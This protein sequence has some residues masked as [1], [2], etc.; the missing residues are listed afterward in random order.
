MDAV[1]S[2][3]SGSAM[4]IKEIH[5]DGFGI[6]NGFSLTGLNHGVNMI[7][8]SNEAGKSSL[9]KFIRYTLFGYP[10]AVNDRMPPLEGGAH[11][12]RIKV[13]LSSGLEAVFERSGK[14]TI[15]LHYNGQESNDQN[16]WSQL[17]G[18]ASARL[19]NN[20]YAFSLDELISL[21]P[22]SESGVED[23]IFSVGLGLGQT[24]LVQVEKNI[25]DG[26]DEVYK[27]YTT[28]SNTCKHYTKLAELNDKQ[29]AEKVKEITG[30]EIEVKPEPFI[31]MVEGRVP[32]LKKV[33]AKYL[34]SVRWKAKRL[35]KLNS[36]DYHCARD[37]KTE[38]VQVHHR[39]YDNVPN[40]PME[41][42]IVL[43]RDCHKKEH[44]LV[45]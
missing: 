16:L 1:G 34:Q 36:V 25:Q 27:F 9:M 6:F 38:G 32:N 14:N 21:D 24:S 22:L 18:N 5:I 19:Y 35:E 23:K 43:C 8:G 11:G 2:T 15:R 42:L 20:V 40:E 37:G 12:G 10:R 44:G 41:D 30:K 33:Y 39:T 4:I 45:D 28:Y 3:N 26:I 31:P 13:M 7:L 17:L 29:F